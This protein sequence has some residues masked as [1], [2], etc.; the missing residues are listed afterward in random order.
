MDLDALVILRHKSLGGDDL[1][2]IMQGKMSLNLVF[3]KMGQVMDWQCEFCPA[4]CMQCKAIDRKPSHAR[5]NSQ[6]ECE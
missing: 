2:H 6:C 1:P 3:V 5:G 4:K